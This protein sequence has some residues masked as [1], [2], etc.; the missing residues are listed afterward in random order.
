L[1]GTICV[2]TFIDWPDGMV[3]LGFA[4]QDNIQKNCIQ[5][6]KFMYGNVDAAIRFFKTFRKHLMEKMGMKQSLA[7][8]C[9][10]YKKNDTGRTVLIAICFV[11]D[12]LL[13]ELKS[14][15]E[16][17]KESVSK[18]FEYKDLGALRKHLGVWY[19]LKIDE[20]GN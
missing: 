15:I 19:K 10:F 5:L 18:R 3:D 7:D 13:F 9:V 8:P 16:W 6:L 11:D 1:E 17:Y 14:E 12:T 20:N 2:S 4:S